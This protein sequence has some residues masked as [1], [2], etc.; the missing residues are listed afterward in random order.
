M[1]ITWVQQRQHPRAQK[2]ARERMLSLLLSDHQDA[3]CRSMI[4]FRLSGQLLVWL[5]PADVPANIVSPIIGL[6]V[7]D[8]CLGYYRSTNLRFIKARPISSL[9]FIHQ[10]WVFNI[11]VLV[12]PS[13][14][15]QS[16]L[17]Q[18]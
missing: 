7:L 6:V 12:G 15:D 10:T 13:F 16:L 5:Y 4:G 9:S 11:G 18:C 14:I 8:R 3:D 17:S 2:S 1:K